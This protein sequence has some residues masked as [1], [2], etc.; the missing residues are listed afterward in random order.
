MERKELKVE[1]SE[2]RAGPIDL[3]REEHQA[4]LLKLELAERALQY[5]L[6]PASETT[7]ERVEVEKML[8]KDLAVAL[9]RALRPHFRKEEEGLFPILA[10][11][12]GSEHGLIEA[13]LHEHAEIFAGFFSWKKALFRFCGEA[14]PAGGELRKEVFDQ[15]LRI[16]SMIRLHIHKENHVLFKVSEVSLTKEEE[17]EV[18]V[19][20]QGM[21]ETTAEEDENGPAGQEISSGTPFIQ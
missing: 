6:R 3:L 12:I 20:M 17:K 7:P 8:L 21:M 10:E 16:V 9:E 4:T 19:R 14:R 13:M 18:M 1:A 15:G 2:K 5:L 11:Y